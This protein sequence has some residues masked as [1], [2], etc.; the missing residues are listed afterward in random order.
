MTMRMN[1]YAA[2]LVI[3]ASALGAQVQAQPAGPSLTTSDLKSGALS[4]EQM[5]AEIAYI[6]SHV[7]M[8]AG[9]K[10]LGQYARFYA[11]DSKGFIHGAYVPIG[12]EPAWTAGVHTVDYDK[13]PS[14]MDGGCSFVDVTFIT[15]IHALRAS[16]HGTA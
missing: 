9:A 1:G 5:N 11:Q 7:Q 15:K 16:C 13:L 12:E 3:M 8:P 6:E 14:V 10:P 2:G 4:A